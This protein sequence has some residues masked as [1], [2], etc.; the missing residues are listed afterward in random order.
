MDFFWTF[1]AIHVAETHFVQTFVQWN[2]WVE[3]R[4]Q[5][6][7]GWNL[8][9][10]RI[11]TPCTRCL[12][13]CVIVICSW[14]F[15][16]AVAIFRNSN[17]LPKERHRKNHLVSLYSKCASQQRLNIRR[18]S[19]CV[20]QTE[21]H[22]SSLFCVQCNAQCNP[23]FLALEFVFRSSKFSSIVPFRLW[24]VHA[25]SWSCLLIQEF[26]SHGSWALLFGVDAG[27]ALLLVSSLLSLSL[28]LLSLV[29]VLR[30]MILKDHLYSTLYFVGS[31]CWVHDSTLY[32]SVNLIILFGHLNTARV[33][34][35]KGMTHH[36][37]MGV[38]WAMLNDSLAD[39]SDRFYASYE[40]EVVRCTPT[41]Y[42]TKQKCMNEN[43]N[44]ITDRAFYLFLYERSSIRILTLTASAIPTS[45][46]RG[47]LKRSCWLMDT[48]A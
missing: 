15:A 41:S 14:S 47:Y 42:R 30:L 12:N 16:N 38:L 37:T 24:L 34:L 31:L 19:S 6:M 3:A 23:L 32:A 27:A 28:L 7:V 20:S 18:A 45:E 44:G 5:K 40:P 25:P 35:W 48:R 10:I 13:G 39:W 8:K 2:Y 26:V 46:G 17:R 22:W 29:I 36:C 11:I 1:T 43:L 21:S 33:K 9:P 4:K